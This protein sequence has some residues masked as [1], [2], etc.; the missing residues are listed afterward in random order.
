MRRIVREDF[1]SYSPSFLICIYTGQWLQSVYPPTPGPATLAYAP[2]MHLTEDDPLA[3]PQ[4]RDQLYAEWRRYWNASKPILLEKSP[5]HMLMT[6]LLQYWFSAERSYFVVVLRH[7]LASTRF[8]W[9]NNFNNDCG[10]YAIKHWLLLQETLF[11]DLKLIKNS[12]VVHYERFAL[13]NAEGK[14]MV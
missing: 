3:T 8:I 5:R 11:D 14:C 12:V 9:N 2:R 13:G 4:N 7:P 6:R 10:E 1:R